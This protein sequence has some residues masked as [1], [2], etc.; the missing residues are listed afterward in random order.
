[1]VDVHLQ[2]GEGVV[3]LPAHILGKG[4]GGHGKGLVRPFGLHFEGLCRQKEVAEVGLGGLQHGV[5]RLLARSGP[6]EADHAEKFFHGGI[7]AVHIAGVVLRLHIGGGLA[8][9]YLEV[10]VGAQPAD[11]VRHQFFLKAAAV[12]PL[13]HQLAQLQQNHFVQSIH[14][15]R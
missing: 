11:G 12:Q 5:G 7:G 1:M 6:G 3:Q 10:A 9:V 14:L 4:D 15:L 13:E 8:G 2:M